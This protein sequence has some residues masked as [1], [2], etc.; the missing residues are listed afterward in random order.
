VESVR[1]RSL[2]LCQS[3]C[4]SKAGENHEGKASEITALMLPRVF[5]TLG[6]A[7]IR[8]DLDRHSEDR[9]I[10]T[11]ALWAEGRSERIKEIR[12]RITNKQAI[13]P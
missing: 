3:L 5:H 12:H 7:I 13:V 11:I 2:S 10:A 6:G 4:F 9:Q 8:P 1:N